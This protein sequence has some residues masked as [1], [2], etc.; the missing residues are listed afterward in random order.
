MR[1]QLAVVPLVIAV[2]VL[3]WNIALSG[4]TAS[5][6]EAPRLFS[7]LTGFCGL[8]I[9]PV[10]VVA[11][12]TGTEAG[13]RTVSGVAWLLPLVVSAFALQVA[14]AVAT[15]LVSVVVGIPILLYNVALAAVALGDFLVGWR[16]S[17]PLG[18]QAAVAARDAV[19]GMTVGRAALL[20]PL[21]LL[22][23]MVAPAYPARWKLSAVARAVLVLIAT[24]MTTLLVLQ[25]PRG[26]GAVRSYAA[27]QHQTLQTRRPDDF[28]IG[29]RL[30]P[31]LHGPPPARAV[32]MDRRLAASF[33]PEVALIVIDDDGATGAALDSLARV[34]EPLVSHGVRIAIAMTGVPPSP[35]DIVHLAAIERVLRRVQPAV[36]FPAMLD[37]VPTLQSR[38]NMPAVWWQATIE[39][40]AR[41]VAR[42]RPETSLAW[43]ASRSDDVDSAVYVWASQPASP[44][45]VL[46]TVSYP[47]FSG[48]AGVD[49]R[50]RAFARWHTLAV[51][52]GGAAQE[53]WLTN[54]GGLPHA[55]GDAA[56]L[57]AIQQ[58]LA[59][60][61][62]QSWITTAIIGEP[63]D[64]AGWL[65]LRAANG[66]I[67]DG[68]SVLAATVKSA[69]E[70]RT[71]R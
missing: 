29:M 44:L 35:D 49:A 68:V 61:S 21:A 63:A 15:G 4:W 27:A 37:P 64:Y 59:W 53:H 14:Y 54:V 69:R 60:G 36:L 46:G 13:S 45:R 50:L 62:R 23:P 3:A 11:I 7:Q 56:Q 47:S 33:A 52:R 65:G 57:A 17:A 25:W 9:A 70:A 34:L 6:R 67:R 5:R 38:Q 30:F 55:H 32:A 10:L 48:L 26:I 20:T 51:A 40:A 28:R 58:A 12:A 71:T 39:S 31:E 18:L 16:G 1:E 19:I 41:V 42:V 24:V 43:S 2:A 22:V 66:R 8:M